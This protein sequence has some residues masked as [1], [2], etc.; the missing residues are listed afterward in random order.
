MSVFNTKPIC[1]LS[2]THQISFLE[3]FGK[4]RVTKNGMPGVVCKARA[5]GPSSAIKKRLS[6]ISLTKS[7]MVT[8][9]WLWVITFIFQSKISLTPLVK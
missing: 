8:R 6:K 2:I 7:T 4:Y 1:A 5:S 9:K 3:S